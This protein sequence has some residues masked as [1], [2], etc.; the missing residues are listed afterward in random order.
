MSH[1]LSQRWYTGILILALALCTSLSIAQALMP[2]NPHL[3]ADVRAAMRQEEGQRTGQWKYR[4]HPV[5]DAGKQFVVNDPASAPAQVLVSGTKEMPCILMKFPDLANTYSTTD[6][7][8]L[9]FT[10]AGVPTGSASD[11][12]TEVSTG[13]LALTGMVDGWYT[14]NNNKAYYG[15]KTRRYADCAYEAAQKA[16]ANSF[17]W[18]PY[19]ND[20]DG[21]VDTLWVI[22]SGLGAEETGNTRTDI[23][24]HSWDFASAGKGVFTTSTPDPYHPGSYIKINNY[25]IQPETSYW[26]GGNGVTQKIVGIGV[27]CHEFGHALG[28]PDLYD[29]GSTNPGE[30]LGNASL[31]AAGS[32]GGDGDD[33]RYPAH[34]DAWCKAD[35]GWISPTVVTADGSYTV[36]DIERSASCYLVKPAGSTV[37]QYFLVENRQHYGYDRTLFATGLFIYHIDTD[38]I[39]S[40]S[41]AN[42]VNNNTHPFGVALEEADATLDSYSSM[43]LFTGSNRGL[44]TDAWPNGAKTAFSPASIPS[45]NTNAG[46]FQGCSISD[47]PA[48]SDAMTV[49]I[50]VT[51][52]ISNTAPVAGNDSYSATAG[53]TLTVRAPG[54]LKNDTDANGDPLTAVLFSNPANGT[55]AL[56]AKGAFTYTPNAGYIGTDTFTYQASDGKAQSN[57]AT[58]TITVAKRG[59]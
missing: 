53:K 55:L 3:P 54:V 58:V 52:T 31:M 48:K 35:L 56:N 57:V 19:D 34:M 36:H 29:T 37:T 17:N 20:H 4:A 13:Q 32:W 11:Y 47:I 33:S 12:Y 16:N 46:V 43:H 6:F 8:H 51:A 10:T 18:A 27:F 14:T 24:S 49:T 26:S 44:S 5:R 30:G 38:I 50:S 28:L 2:P 9:L 40:Y 21:Y 39:N 59:K 7:Q 23:W 22:H 15:D 25:I 45:T 42:S 1:S 41:A